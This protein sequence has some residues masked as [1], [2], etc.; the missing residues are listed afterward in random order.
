MGGGETVGRVSRQLGRE[1]KRWA[2]KEA[3]EGEPGVW[4]VSEAAGSVTAW[5]WPVLCA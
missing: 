2:G 3:E 5:I 1:R 4:E